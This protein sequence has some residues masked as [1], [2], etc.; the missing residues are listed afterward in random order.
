MWQSIIVGVVGVVV[1]FLIVRHIVR[2][3]CDPRSACQGC[4]M[5]C[6][7]CKHEPKSTSNNR[8]K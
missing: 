2:T 5:D 3:I 6:K 8:R 1:L 4:N 7:G